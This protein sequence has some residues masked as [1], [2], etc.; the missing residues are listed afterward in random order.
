MLFATIASL[1]I[2]TLFGWMSREGDQRGLGFLAAFTLVVCALASAGFGSL[3]G[4]LYG[5]IAL[6]L[7]TGLV[8]FFATARRAQPTAQ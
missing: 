7:A 5:A 6:G 3:S 4:S 1:L 8:S 2:G